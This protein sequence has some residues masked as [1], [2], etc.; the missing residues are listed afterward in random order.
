[1]AAWPEVTSEDALEKRGLSGL[2]GATA[3]RNTLLPKAVKKKVEK[4]LFSLGKS[5]LWK[6]EGRHSRLCWFWWG[7]VAFPRTGLWLGSV[8]GSV[9]GSALGTRGLGCCRAALAQGRSPPCS[10][11]HRAGEEAGGR[12]QS[13]DR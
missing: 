12:T 3:Q 2:P 1:M 7:S 9:L 6:Q 4:R 5:S 13:G 11:P 10:S 8:L